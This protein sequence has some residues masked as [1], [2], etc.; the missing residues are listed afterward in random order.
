M[1]TARAS[2]PS[3][4]PRVSPRRRRSSRFFLSALGLEAQRLGNIGQP[5]YDPSVDTSSG[6]L[7]LEVSSFQ[8]VDLDVAPAV[9][10]VTSLG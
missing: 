5:P 4:A 7:V 10:V 9:I 8:V 2:S 6:W 1:S 3:R